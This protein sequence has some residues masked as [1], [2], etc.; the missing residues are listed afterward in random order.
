MGVIFALLIFGAIILLAK[1]HNNA[2]KKLYNN[3]AEIKAEY[4]LAGVSFVKEAEDTNGIKA[5]IGEEKAADFEPSITLTRWEDEVKFSVKP[6][7]SDVAKA[8]RTL[9]FDK[10]KIIFNTPKVEYQMYDLPKAEGM[11]QGG[12]EFEIILKEKPT[13]NVVSLNIETQNLDFFYQPPLNIEMAN[14]TCTPTDCEGFHRPENVV[15]SYAVYYKDR[16]SGDYTALG[17]KNYRAGKAFHIYRPKIIDSAGTET[18]GILNIDKE[19]GILSVEIDQKFLDNAVYPIHHA[20]G[21]TLGYITIGASDDYANNDNIIGAPAQTTSSGTMSKIQIAAWYA[22]GDKH[23][24]MAVYTNRGTPFTD[25]MPDTLVL[26]SYSGEL[27]VT[28]TTKPTQDSEWLAST[29][30]S[31]TLAANTWYWICFSTDEYSIYQAYDSGYTNYYTYIQSQAFSIFPQSGPLPDSGYHDMLNSIY[32]T[33]AP[34][35]AELKHTV[36]PAGQGGDYDTLADAIAHLVVVHPNLVT[37]NVYALIEI[38]GDW[39]GVSDTAAVTISGLTTDATHYLY[40][41]TTAAARHAG[42]WDDTKYNLVTNDETSIT[43]ADDCVRLDGL[44]IGHSAVTGHDR[45]GIFIYQQTAASDVRILNFIIKMSGGSSWR[46]PGIYVWNNNTVLRLYNTI[47]YGFGA[48]SSA[49][50][51]PL[52]FEDGT[53]YIYSCTLIGDIRAILG[54]T[55]TTCKNVYA[56]TVGGV[57]FSNIETMVTCASS[58]ISGS[59]GLQNIA[60]DTSNFVNVTPGSEDFHIPVGSALKD[61][62]TNTSGDAAPMNFTTDIGGQTRS[63]TWDIGADEYGAAKGWQIKNGTIKIKHGTVKIK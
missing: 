40:I 28:R 63:G 41:Y 59:E 23:L 5:I 1:P 13:T 33:Y 31:G 2:L 54:G 26:N 14:S 42:K 16:K 43:I 32:V 39:T 44:Q 30:V 18:W 51:A 29:D 22:S 48:A 49:G 4:K 50:N 62:G 37:A 45:Y 8:D 10:D 55:H 11:E 24:K 19:A 57:A 9:Q 61:V 53:E 52:W 35:P 38:D 27:T 58:D 12:Y 17:G 25:G 47:I 3:S 36:K 56:Y 6:D 21:L 34:A 7:I 46:E 15:G 20:A 60:K